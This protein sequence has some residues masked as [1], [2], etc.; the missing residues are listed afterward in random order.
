MR[1]ARLVI[2]TDRLAM[3]MAASLG[4]ALVLRLDRD[5]TADE[6]RPYGL[7]IG[8]DAAEVARYVRRHLP[9]VE[10]TQQALAKQKTEANGSAMK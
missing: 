3:R 4:K 6:G 7:Y 8:H 10:S 1:R 5:E 2:G 9:P